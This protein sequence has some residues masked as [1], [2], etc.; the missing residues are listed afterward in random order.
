MQPLRSGRLP[1]GGVGSAE[2][3][4]KRENPSTQKVLGME[5]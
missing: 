5:A 4:E 3:L 1:G 2:T